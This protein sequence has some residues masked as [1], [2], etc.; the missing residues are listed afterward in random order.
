MYAGV[1]LLTALLRIL[2]V[3]VTLGFAC[4]GGKLLWLCY[5]RGRERALEN[6]S[7]A[8]PDKDPAWLKKTA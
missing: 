8:Y 5:A 3:S 2:P 7:A 6:L 1:R 4:G